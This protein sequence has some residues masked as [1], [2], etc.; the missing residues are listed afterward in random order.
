MHE[1]ILFT[2]RNRRQSKWDGQD[3]LEKPEVGNFK[4]TLLSNII[5]RLQNPTGSDSDKKHVA[6][7]FLK[8]GRTCY[9]MVK[10]KNNFLIVV[11]LLGYLCL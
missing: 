6:Q 2:L 11:S 7:T 9:D 8:K 3:A 10:N 4:R 5:H 1:G